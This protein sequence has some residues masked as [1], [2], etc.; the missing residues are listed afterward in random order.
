MV[1]YRDSETNSLGGGSAV[2]TMFV[3]NMCYHKMI[4]AFGGGLDFKATSPYA[5]K[6]AVNEAMDVSK[7]A[8]VSAVI[9]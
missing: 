3:R 5:V 6:E 9:D 8:L 4:E 7:P 2:T 1:V